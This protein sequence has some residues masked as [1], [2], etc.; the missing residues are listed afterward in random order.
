MP[1][2]V[3]DSSFAALMTSHQHPPLNTSTL[4]PSGS[5][6][7]SWT[8]PSSFSRWLQNPNGRLSSK[9]RLSTGYIHF[10]K[11]VTVGDSPKHS[12]IEGRSC[13][14]SLPRPRKTAHWNFSSS[15]SGWPDWRPRRLFMLGRLGVILR[16]KR[17]VSSP[18]EISPVATTLLRPVLL[19]QRCT[20]WIWTPV[21]S[22]PHT[23]NHTHTHPDRRAET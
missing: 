21:Y 16:L 5:W 3:S 9:P 14:F 17:L 12:E 23:S 13:F 4:V 10:T 2:E 15:C 18:K 20:K 8:E 6:D 19:V 22:V 1:S 11:L 7:M